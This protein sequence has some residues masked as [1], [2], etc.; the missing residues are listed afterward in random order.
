M[1]PHQSMGSSLPQAPAWKPQCS[2]LWGGLRDEEEEASVMPL[3]MMASTPGPLAPMVMSVLHCT[4]T[5]AGLFAASWRRAEA[6]P[7]FFFFF[8]LLV[9]IFWPHYAASGI[10]VS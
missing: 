2:Q 10:L 5:V 4:L 6:L 9:F 7:T 3:C 1:T 8:L